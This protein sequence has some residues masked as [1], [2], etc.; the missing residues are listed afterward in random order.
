MKNNN[1]AI[2]R[3]I[4]S[5]SL[6]KNKKRNFF[7]VMAI[8]LNTFMI[9]SV[10]SIGISYYESMKAEIMQFEQAKDAGESA[11]INYTMGDPK[12]P[13][14]IFVYAIIILFL[15]FVG[16]LLIYNVLYISISND[17]R[18][19][20]LLKTIGTTPNQI[21][22]IVIGQVLILC[23][24]AIPIGLILA[25][26]LSIVVIPFAIIV[27]SGT[28]ISFSPYI[29]L[30]AALFSLV[31]AL[32][33]SVSPVKKASSISPIEAVKYTGDEIQKSRIKYDVHG[34]P[35]RMA[36]RNI[37]RNRKRTIVVFLSL[38]LGMTLF[39]LMTT[40]VFSMNADTYASSYIDGDFFIAIQPGLPGKAKFDEIFLHNIEQIPG[41]I[42]MQINTREQGCMKYTE[43]LSYQL[44]SFVEEKYHNFQSFYG[45]KEEM[46]KSY[47][48]YPLSVWICGIDKTA[49]TD[50]NKNLSN[51]LDIDAFERGEFALISTNSPELF[52][53]VID[54]EITCEASEKTFI[55]PL[56]GFV[57]DSYKWISSGYPM[58]PVFV[59]NTF[60]EQY[61]D[62]PLI[63]SITIN[64]D[65]K[66]S[67]QALA[68]LHEIVSVNNE[69]ILISKIE[70]RQVAQNA[71]TIL[72]ALGGSIS[73]ILGM[74]GIFNFVNVMSVG[75]LIRKREFATLESV[76]MSSRQIRKM[77]ICEG[78]G[79]AATTLLL[80]LF[81]GN[82]ITV[83]IYKMFEYAQQQASYSLFDFS[84]PIIPV[85]IMSLSILVICIITPIIIYRSINQ[86][87]IVERLREAE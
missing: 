22:K 51:P 30:G 53:D 2:V 28:I 27:E 68:A 31:T 79:Y 61:I 15:M 48:E 49:I 69:L 37:F 70:E 62:E 20:G 45:S 71:K 29:Y 8:L 46:K 38:S 41:F 55:I 77:L 16:Y 17:V 59:S 21:N 81:V 32:I 56:G 72:F 76:G 78:A 6:A 66:Y 13:G 58:P 33:G 74:I 50:L 11:N 10:I 35:H 65:E 52:N 26:L 47:I 80:V 44:D 4:T 1:A 3:K 75:I 63:N 23:A 7:L 42:E 14:T 19:Y 43:A 73:I 82:G 54:M 83:G 40:I 87:S 86:A 9:A 64:V 5:R 25:A 36:V 18:F 34:K 84:Y 67:A 12:S 24:I 57:P 85:I 60:L 39:V